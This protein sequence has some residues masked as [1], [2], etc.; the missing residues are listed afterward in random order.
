M[1]IFAVV[2]LALCVGLALLAL[3]VVRPRRHAV[4]IAWR[5]GA[6]GMAHPYRWLMPNGDI[7]E[8]GDR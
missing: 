8:D 3:R 7:W 6:D 4:A 2:L 5:K 1:I